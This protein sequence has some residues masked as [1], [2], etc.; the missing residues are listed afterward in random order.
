MKIAQDIKENSVK[1]IYFVGI[2]GVGMASLA[3]L[4]HEAGFA[5]SGSDVPEVYVT[6]E[7]LSKKNFHIH[8]TVETKFL[9]K[10]IQDKPEECLVIT[11]AAHDGLLNPQ[12]VFSK[13][14]K[15]PVLTHGQAVG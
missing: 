11:T 12:C 2:K 9:E 1:R 15:I 14:L 10:F 4:S 13:S 3:I 5:V 7:V 6:D 8:L